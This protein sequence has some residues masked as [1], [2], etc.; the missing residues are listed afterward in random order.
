MK[1]GSFTAGTFIPGLI[2]FTNAPSTG[3]VEVGGASLTRTAGS[4]DGY[5]GA[6]PF[7]VLDGFS[8][9]THL[10]VAQISFNQVT[11]GQQTVR[12]RALARLAEAG[13]LRGD[14]TGDGVVDFADFFPLANAFGTQ[15]GQPGF[16][17]AFDLDD[18]GEIGFGDFFIFT[19]QWGG[20]GG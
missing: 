4:G 17:P 10:A 3:A 16:D 2:A 8:G 18:S 5:L 1:P 14:F 19:N 20:S 9:Q 7:Q 13:G 15:R 11:G 6:I 12:Q